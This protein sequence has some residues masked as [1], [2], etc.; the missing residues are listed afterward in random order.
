VLKQI[1]KTSRL[2]VNTEHGHRL[3]TARATANPQ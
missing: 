2:P 3:P 1:N